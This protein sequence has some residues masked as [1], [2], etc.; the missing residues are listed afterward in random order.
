MAKRTLLALVFFTA[1]VSVPL[2]SNAWTTHYFGSN[3]RYGETGMEVSFLQEYL[4]EQ[5][6]F[7]YP[8]I[9]KYFGSVTFG[10]VKA[11]QAANG[12]PNTG[13][14]GP[15]SRAFVNATGTADPVTTT[16]TVSATS[17]STN[18]A[19]TSVADDPVPFV[20]FPPTNITFEGV[21]APTSAAP[22]VSIAIT[23]TSTNITSGATTT[24]AASV[25]NA[26]DTAITWSA[27]YGTINASGTYT[28][29]SALGTSTITDTI[30]ATS[31]ADNTKI[32]TATIAVSSGMLGWWPLGEGTGTVATEISGNAS[33]GAWSGTAA[34]TSGYYSTGFTLSTFVGNFNGSDDEVQVSSNPPAAA[35]IKTIGFWAYL[36]SLSG[37]TE[38]VSKSTGGQGEEVIIAGGTANFYVMGS[39]VNDTAANNSF[40]T[41]AGWYYLT[42]T[43]NGPDSVTS[44]YVNGTLEGTST[45]PDSIGDTT[46]LTFGNWDAG[47]RYFDGQLSDIQLYD[48]PVT[49]AEVQTLYKQQ[50]AP[51]LITIAPTSTTLMSGATTTFT[52]TIA[53]ATN[54]AVTWS[55][56]HGTIN[57]SGT[58][59]AV[60]LSTSTFLA[61]DTVTAVSVADNTKIATASVSVTNGLADWWKL[62]E[63]TGTIAY[64]SINSAHDGTW[65]GTQSSP[66]STYYGPSQTSTSEAGYFVAASE[67]YIDPSLTM[68]YSTTST[69][70][71]TVW[72]DL[73]SGINGTNVILGDRGF[74]PWIKIT[75]SAFEYG[76]G[77]LISNTIPSNQWEFISVVKSGTSFYYYQNGTLEGSAS[78]SVTGTDVPFFIGTDPNDTGDGYSWGSIGDVRIYSTP[79]ASSSIQTIYN[80][81]K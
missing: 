15:I 37:T 77:S 32:A 45:A 23:S 4:A 72:L 41:G 26:S 55:A 52:A 24:F 75:P 81:T 19:V 39:S 13:F 62:N 58:Y 10:A 59:T 43:Q 68:S 50:T 11:W 48:R 20:E 29:P 53:D 65:H 69:F 67:D 1:I 2:A 38:M 80:Q 78:S 74:N 17:T 64:D 21:P 42:A 14:F 54:T 36:P 46:N 61:T 28:A 18:A 66:S 7:H 9:T 51:V 6:Y 34:G 44:I 70:T 16:T 27:L 76:S 35:N 79:L 49:A 22:A 25:S 31:Q 47:G 5:G 3:L 40:Y 33:S 12:I 73:N 60:T 71:W 63:G 56:L 30:T 57:A 8:S